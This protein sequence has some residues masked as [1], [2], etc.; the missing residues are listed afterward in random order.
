MIP[1]LITAFALLVCCANASQYPLIL[2]DGSSIVD[3][4]DRSYRASPPAPVSY[5]SFVKHHVAPPKPQQQLT[6]VTPP[7]PAPPLRSP[8]RA[9]SVPSPNQPDI[10]SKLAHN[11]NRGVPYVLYVQIVPQGQDY[12]KFNGN[13]QSN[14]QQPSHQPTS[15]RHS[16]ALQGE[17]VFVR[18]KVPLSQEYYTLYRSVDTVSPLLV[19]VQKPAYVRNMLYSTRSNSGVASK[20]LSYSPQL[21]YVRHV[22]QRA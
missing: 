11:P 3:Q 7:I 1:K 15:H 6:T 8:P 12:S 10:A 21:S 16:T 19:A 13:H 18:S 20:T 5:V 22:H 14:V 2:K 17:P 4:P 9:F